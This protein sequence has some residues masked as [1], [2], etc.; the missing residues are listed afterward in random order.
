MQCCANQTALSGSVGLKGFF[1]LVTLVKLT[2]KNLTALNFSI[3]QSM[4][5]SQK[6]LDKFFSPSGFKVSTIPMKK[7]Y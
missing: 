6:W 4:G 7:S 5:F 3:N 1:S 2:F